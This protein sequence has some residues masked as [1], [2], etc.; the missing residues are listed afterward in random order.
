MHG[1][2]GRGPFRRDPRQKVPA[3]LG[4]SPQMR[5]IDAWIGMVY[6]WGEGFRVLG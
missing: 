6:F 2:F 4:N 3:T 5:K 1:P